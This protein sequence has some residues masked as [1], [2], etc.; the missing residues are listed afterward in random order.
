[1]SIWSNMALPHPPVRADCRP[2]LAHLPR[3][4]P[5]R[6]V[7]RPRAIYVVAT[8]VLAMLANAC[9]AAEYLTD[10]NYFGAFA[11]ESRDGRSGC[12]ALDSSAVTVGMPVD[13]V[14]LS[15]PQ[16]LLK[17]T[18]VSKSSAECT[19]YF[20]AS[21]SAAFYDIGITRG[22]FEAHELGVLV[23]PGATVT[24]AKV[25]HVTAELGKGPR[26]I[27][28]RFFECSS[29]EGIHVGLRAASGESRI[30][31]HDYVYLGI[32]VEPTC[33]KPDYAGI[34]AL[35]KAFSRDARKR[36]R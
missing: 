33:R 32:N 20:Q 25:G 15:K 29:S 2:L 27:Q 3:T 31:W 4:L 5:D 30:I 21:D 22:R 34:E 35:G 26:K 28:Y 8:L 13:I 9:G 11:T 12:A 24:E 36:A 6:V 18:V 19:R 7:R 10:A 1:M 14:V 16:R 17:G 23:L